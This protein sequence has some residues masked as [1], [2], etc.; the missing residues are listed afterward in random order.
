MI[1]ANINIIHSYRGGS[2]AGFIPEYQEV[3]SNATN[4]PYSIPT[5]GQQISQ[6]AFY[7]SIVDAGVWDDVDAGWIYAN[8]GGQDFG[9]LN[10]KDPTLFQ[11]T[12]VNSPSFISNV[13]FSGNGATSYINTNFAIDAATK[14]S[15]TSASFFINLSGSIGTNGVEFGGGN[16]ATGVITLFSTYFSQVRL[17][18]TAKVMGGYTPDIGSYFGRR[19]NTALEVWKNDSSI[20][21]ATES[22][23][24]PVN[25]YSIYACSFNNAGAVSNHSSTPIRCLFVG[26]SLDSTKRTALHNAFN[27]Y[28]TSI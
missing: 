10:I 12:L 21:T 1:N 25:N 22:S 16:G 11:C 20:F 15:L 26:R 2:S 14:M 5:T 24:S 4:R 23:Y 28:I 3:L 13:G 18:S 8:N 6:N 9:T 27:T 7:T 19:D 17:V